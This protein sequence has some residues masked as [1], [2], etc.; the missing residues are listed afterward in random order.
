[1][2][3]A[4]HTLDGQYQAMKIDVDKRDSGAGLEV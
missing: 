2:Q 1:M 4:K 3:V